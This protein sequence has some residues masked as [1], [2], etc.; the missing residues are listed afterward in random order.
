[1]EAFNHWYD[2]QAAQIQSEQIHRQET[3]VSNLNTKPIPVS[4]IKRN[5]VAEKTAQDY[6]FELE[7][8]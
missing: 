6:Y 7:Q 5:R 3:P 2:S 4:T 1:L 8:D